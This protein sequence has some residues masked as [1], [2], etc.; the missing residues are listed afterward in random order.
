[1]RAEENR[2]ILLVDD[3][4]ELHEDFR[5]ILVPRRSAT[6]E[7][8]EETAR[9]PGVAA[10]SGHSRTVFELTS[11]M[12][13]EEALALT[14]ASCTAGRPFAVAFVDMRMPPGLDGLTTMTRLWSV[15]PEL[16][17]VI[18]TAHPDCSWSEIHSALRTH[19]RWLVLKKPCDKIEVLQTA[20]AL[21]EKWSLARL[22]RERQAGLEAMVDEHT[23]Q[24][25]RTSRVKN[26]F[27]A[28]V[29][30]ELLTPMNGIA[31][32]QE[33]L[34]T[35][36]LDPEQQAM[37]NDARACSAR[38]LQLLQQVV[39]YNQAEAGTLALEPVEFDPAGFLEEIA[40]GHRARA[41]HKGLRLVVRPTPELPATMRA[42]AGVIREVVRALLDNAVKFTSRGVVEISMHAAGGRLFCTVRD[43]GVGMT[44]DQVRWIM[45]PFAQVDGGMARHNT[46]F[47]LGL[48]L[49]KRLVE[50]LAGRLHISSAP[51]SGTT[52]AFS[53]LLP[54]V[55]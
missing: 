29:S 36:K 24:L 54:R 6:A 37:L 38:L 23:E 21:T 9:L 3:D 18:C 45:E 4:A 53:T 49:A 2:R 39:A 11:A 30:H 35:T 8:D 14:E 42:P 47:G 46:G 48:A 12:Q 27:L 52:A 1:M 32:M 50:L 25:H 28:N 13:G 44:P 5:R 26:E 51:D 20:H 10:A 31:G 55:A 34:A 41:A 22:A 19:D 16:F 43:T 7:L 33:L 17:V 15:D 40:A